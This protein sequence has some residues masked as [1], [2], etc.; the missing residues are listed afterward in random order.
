MQNRLF[1]FGLH[2]NLPHSSGL[3]R[4]L[5]V[6]CGRRWR[7]F[8]SSSN[9]DALLTAH[10]HTHKPVMVEQVL[11][12]LACAH[13][14][15]PILDGT[16]GGGGHSAALLLR[17]P[18]SRV[19]AF[20]RDESAFGNAPAWLSVAQQANRLECHV[21]PFSQTAPKIVQPESAGAILLD[22]GLVKKTFLVFF[23][24]SF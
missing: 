3:R 19:I 23:N 4:S 5:L 16:F 17:H 6:D 15:L 20:D 11:D 1:R 18:K 7:P 22:V 9:L 21:G 2:L 10:E 14:E 12:A 24:F 8:S 13:S